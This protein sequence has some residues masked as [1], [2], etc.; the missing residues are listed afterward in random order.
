MSIS[1]IVVNYHTALLLPG[2]LSDLLGHSAVEKIYIVDNSGEVDCAGMENSHVKVLKPGRNI[3]FGA[4]VNFAAKEIKNK[5]ILIVN[6]DVRFLNGCIDHLL[7]AALDNNAVLTGPR[8]FWDDKKKFRLPPSQ[9]TS[10][11][12][13]FALAS[14]HANRLDADSISFYWQL[15]HQRFWER[16]DPFI[17]FFLSGACVLIDREWA[18]RNHNNKI[19]DERFFLYF[20][21]NDI[22]VRAM[23][24]GRPPL[25]VPAAEALHYYA[26]SRE[27]EKG[28][29]SLM[30]ISHKEFKK[31]YYGDMNY[32]LHNE[33][34]FDLDLNGTGKL[35]NK[36][37]F[38]LK[39][40]H[41]RGKLYFEI[42]IN[43]V[44]IPFVQADIFY[45]AGY[46]N[47]KFFTIPE[48]IWKRLAKGTYYSRIRDSIKGILKIWKWQKI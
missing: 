48:D 35:I 30:E 3:G 9:G 36:T 12:M 39:G 43:P 5:F 7:A 23:N 21:D 10:S 40:L 4:G 20:E 6:P 22:S 41:P 1:A 42:G 19:F 46:F 15:R 37:S 11:W 29:A 13:D 8:F 27:P 26:Q 44:F 32:S 14:A 2:V 38:N 16:D 33:G 17:E 45:P 47:E 18:F 28:K 24:D 31:K 34:V 25:C